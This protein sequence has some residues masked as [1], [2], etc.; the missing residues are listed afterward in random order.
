MTAPGN[1]LFFLALTFSIFISGAYALGRIHQW[2]KNGLDRDE[3]Y[4]RGYDK[5]SL[6][7]LDMM[8]R[9]SRAGAGQGA[10][11]TPLAGRT[12]ARL[13]GRHARSADR[14]RPYP[15]PREECDR[16]GT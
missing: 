1:N 13:H 14:P 8:A 5:A 2:H 3:E 15:L 16:T 7:I 6:S 12:R 11:V 10:T 4:R 9:Q